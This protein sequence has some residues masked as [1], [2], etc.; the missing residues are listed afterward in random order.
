MQDHAAFVQQDLKRYLDSKD[1]H[2]LFSKL[3]ESVLEEKPDNPPLFLVRWL[4]EEFPHETLAISQHLRIPEDEEKGDHDDDEEDKKEEEEDDDDEDEDDSIAVDKVKRKQRAMAISGESL[5]PNDLQEL[6]E[7]IPT[8]EKSEE[9]AERLLN[10][11]ESSPFLCNLHEDQKRRIVS[12]FKELPGE[13]QAGENI[14]TQG[15]FGDVLYLL[16]RGEVDVLRRR[17]E[18]EEV[19]HTYESG[20]TFGELAIMYNS[21]RQA[22]CRAKT[23]CKLWTLD[24][25]SFKVLAL[26][27]CIQRRERYMGFLSNVPVLSSLSDMELMALAD[28]LKENEFKEEEIVCSEGERGDLFYI[29]QEGEAIVTQRDEAS[30]FENVIASLKQGK[31]FGEIA[32]I[33]NKNRTATVRAAPKQSLKALSI[34]RAT[35]KR[36]LG[37]L[38]VIMKRNMESYNDFFT[39]GI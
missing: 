38:E 5:D 16:E 15:E 25:Y 30:G 8:I 33:A 22:T 34:D 10:I 7:D 37:P 12:A 20:S 36:I 19:V 13:T 29:I 28:A 31:C 26:A 6:L 9:A 2:S 35:F 27:A 24:R 23:S 39:Q 1:F 21:P 17:G 11:V 14:I 32:L 18:E 4:L 3:V